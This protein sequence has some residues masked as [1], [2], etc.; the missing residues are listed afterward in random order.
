[1]VIDTDQGRAAQIANT[2]VEVFQEKLPVLMNVDNVNVLS[3]ANIEEDPSPVSPNA[4]SN[5]AIAFVL[6]GMVGLGIT[7]LL[8][9][10]DTTIANEKDVERHTELPVLGVISSIH[11]EDILQRN[12][13]LHMRGG[14]GINDLAKKKTV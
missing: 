4:K 1:T 7:F 9:Y 2:T 8:E 10:L 5:I 14:R 13:A 6:G 11:D 3:E 12:R